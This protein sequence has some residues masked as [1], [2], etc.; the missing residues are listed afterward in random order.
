VH[1]ALSATLLAGLLAGAVG[2]CGIPDRTEVVPVKAGPS[3]GLTAGGDDTPTRPSR[4]DTTNP[5]QFI[6]NYLQA[7][8]GDLNGATDR[9]REFIAPSARTRFQ[10]PKE[11]RVVRLA[12]KPLVNPGSAK[13][14]LKVQQV[15]VISGPNGILEPPVSA[16]SVTSYDFQVDMIEGQNGLYVTRAPSV[17]LLSDTALNAYYERRAIY[18]W[19]RQGTALV[20]DIRYMSP[21]IPTERQP[22]EIIKWLAAGPSP[23]LSS[24]VDGL[25]ENTKVEGNVPAVSDDKLQI[26][27]SGV[28]LA[29]DDPTA[30]VRLRQQLM[31]SLRPYLAPKLELRFDNQV[32][33]VYSGTDY[34]SSNPVYRFGVRPERFAVYDGQIRRLAQSMNPTMP[35]PLVT[36]EVN[37]NVRSAALSSA[38]DRTYAALVVN[39]GAKQVLKVGTAVTGQPAA[40]RRAVLPGPAGRPVWA[41]TG[42]ENPAAAVGLIVVA[43]KIYSFGIGGRVT[44]RL[45]EWQAGPTGVQA[46]SVAPDGRRV[47]VV[48]GGRLYLSVLSTSGNSVQFSPQRSIRVLLNELSAVDWSSEGFV[49]VAGVR[50]EANRV[51]I[52]DVSIDGALQTDRQPDL[53]TARITQLAAYP[54]NPVINSGDANVVAYVADNVAY[55]VLGEPKSITVADIAGAVPSPA[56]G[57]LPSSPFFL[58]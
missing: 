26:N 42:T 54:A 33:E 45:V 35:V 50:G 5:T 27:L 1:A 39:E 30:P 12:E 15:G 44:P 16:A 47:A 38:G 40:F 21:S 22:T 43:G 52:T 55:D 13:V 53:G 8:A 9:A 29:P 28:T 31:W 41:V 23:W 17:L 4:G 32:Q 3:A 58:N 11:I 37:R 25:P 56:P 20:P 48:A 51:A 49:V 18:F 2:A 14:S 19:N 24:A 36:P 10:P 57:V 6:E 7:A 34:L 46:V